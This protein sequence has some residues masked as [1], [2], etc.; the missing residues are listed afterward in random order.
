MRIRLL[1]PVE[2]VARDGRPVELS[3]AKRRTV[4]ATLALDLNQ[5]V[6][7]DR[8]IDVAWEGNPPPSA[9]AAL[10]GHI[11][12][13]RKQFGGGVELVTRAPGY[14]LVAD[15]SL[16]DVT[17]FDDLVAQARTVPAAH[18]VELLRSALALWR[19]RALADVPVDQL[20]EQASTQ[21]E[22]A[23][24]AALHDL[25]ER[26]FQLGRITEVVDELR[27]AADHYPMREPLV[28]LVV[29][30]LHRTGRQAEALRLFHRTRTM[31]AEELG[32]DPGAGLRETYQLVLTGSPT[33]TDPTA[34]PAQLVRAN[35]GL[36]GRAR[37]MAD[38][39]ASLTGAPPPAV[40]AGPPSGVAAGVGRSNPPIRLLTG[41]AG[42]GKTSLAL[43]WCHQVAADLPDGQLFVDLKGFGADDPVEP[44][45]ALTGF[46]RALG[47]AESRIPVG[48]TEQAALYRSLL[49]DRRML[50]LLDNACTA[51]QV[52]PLLPGSPSCV[53]LVTSRH[54]LDDLVV[55]EGAVPLLVDVLEPDDA[56]TVLGL[57][58]G[59]ERVAAE[60]EAARRL[61][62]LCDGLPLALRVAAGRLATRP[63]WT[64]GDVVDHLAGTL[65]A[66][67]GTGLSVR[68]AL[69]ASYR[70]LP[71]RARR[72]LG[73][74]RDDI[75]PRTAAA[76]TG[77]SVAEARADLDA[78]AALHLLHET[79]RDSYSCRGLVRLFVNELA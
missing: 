41:P 36:V 5:V 53:V 46:L 25:G 7:G 21:L 49:A 6:S 12:Q 35:R 69:E 73:L 58:A 34:T 30:A 51:E 60:P 76:L 48:V 57:I 44:G 71:P 29:R 14:Q 3:A 79:G 24:L 23:R 4:L 15:R 66:L 67:P 28:E 45:V 8:L 70:R 1:G 59:P 75:D 17:R 37:H 65:P 11:A 26:L 18:A 22:E 13:L 31:L 63:Q 42:G 20:R 52:R 47:V 56:V 50:V 33:A 77:T 27:D 74:V 61:A 55:T 10:Q 19:G 78:I 2:L 72:L 40:T 62:E 39:T 16:V 64:V 38:L 32:V 68:A 9:R 54:R 43:H